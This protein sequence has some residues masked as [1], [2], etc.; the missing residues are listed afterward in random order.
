MSID[1]FVKSHGVS[2][3]DNN[4]IDQ[5]CLLL[6]N[7]ADYFDCAIDIVSHARKGQASPGDAERERGAS[8]KKDAG[9]LVRTLTGMTEAEADTF[10]ILAQERGSLIRIDDA[11]VNLKPRSADAMWFK[12]I[13]VPL[14]N[15]TTDY[16]NGDNV[17]TVER[18]TPPDNFNVSTT[19][20]NAIIDDIDKGL[21]NGQRYS[22]ANKA[23]DRAVWKVIVKH[24]DRTEKQAREMIRIWVKNQVLIAMTYDDP[25]KR[26]KLTGLTANPVKRPG[27]E[28][29]Y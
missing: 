19:I 20:L 6:A 22:D 17:Q 7:I 23:T 5:V 25:V 4:A 3:N 27:Q 15:Q 2:K 13:G 1:P 18:W 9:R 14:G 26:K 29:R 21:E 12:L 10:G 8:A 28:V 11:K 24:L 16:P